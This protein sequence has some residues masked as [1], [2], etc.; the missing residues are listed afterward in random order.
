MDNNESE[1][2]DEKTEITCDSEV[3]DIPDRTSDEID[4]LH[5]MIRWEQEEKAR[6]LIEQGDMGL[7]PDYHKYPSITGKGK[8]ASI[9]RATMG[10]SEQEHKAHLKRVASES[11]ELFPEIYLYKR[12]AKS[13]QG[14]YQ[15]PHQSN[16]NNSQTPTYITK[17]EFIELYSAVTF[18]NGFGIALNAHVIIQ[19]GYLGYT[20]HDMAAKVLQDDFLRHMNLWYKYNNNDRQEKYKVHLPHALHWVYSNEFTRNSF[21]THLLVG[22]PFEMRK[23]FRKWV[24]NRITMIWKNKCE[25]EGIAKPQPKGVIKIVN[26]PSHPIER[27]WIFFQYLCKGV[28]P[29]ATVEIPGYKNPVPISRFI[30]FPC[31]N[32][33]HLTCKNRIGLSRNLGQKEREKSKFKSLM[34]LGCFDKRLLYTSTLYD[35]WHRKNPDLNSLL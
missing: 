30:Q 28:D 18:A 3:T 24:K 22:I 17:K 1:K 14:I 15:A 10:D 20:D 6:N 13:K 19:W 8:Y 11:Q 27:Q 4:D 25:S 29:H 2:Q 5:Y 33:G 12:T 35:E 16:A 9:Y 34:E 7:K 23:E 21:H 32:P 26:P 31:F